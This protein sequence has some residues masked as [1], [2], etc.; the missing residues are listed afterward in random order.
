MPFEETQQRWG[1]SNG[2]RT[3]LRGQIQGLPI[4]LP[5][6]SYL[7]KLQLIQT[8]DEWQRYKITRYNC[9]KGRGSDVDR[10]KASWKQPGLLS[11]K[12]CCGHF[13][14]AA[15]YL[16]G[17]TSSFAFGREGNPMPRP[18][19]ING[20]GDSRGSSNDGVDIPR[21]EVGEC[22]VG[23]SAAERLAEWSCERAGVKR[24][25]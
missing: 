3:N 20:R 7:R 23:A 22:R 25:A 21:L 17:L 24:L 12:R 6:Y 16:A 8:N 15:D 2:H 18:L 19:N 4:M 11:G 5:Q 10:A 1:R 13:S 14:T 9:F